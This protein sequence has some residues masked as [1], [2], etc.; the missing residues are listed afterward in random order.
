MT[1]AVTSKKKVE[2]TT[3]QIRFAYDIAYNR[4]EGKE[5]TTKEKEAKEDLIESLDDDMDIILVDE[6]GRTVVD[7][8]HSVRTGNIDW[9]RF[10]ADHPEYDYDSYRKPATSMITVKPGPM[11]EAI[12]ETQ[13]LNS[14]TGEG[15]EA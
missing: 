4:R 3:E 7:F 11:I 1:N 12:A 2:A 10:M 13:Q 9:A 5:A 6:K 8:T 15:E 14:V